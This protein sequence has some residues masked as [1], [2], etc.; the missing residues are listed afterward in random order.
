[1]YPTQS[2]F[3]CLNIQKLILSGSSHS[4]TNKVNRVNSE[5]EQQSYSPTSQSER[6]T[7]EHFTNHRQNRNISGQN[8]SHSHSSNYQPNMY[9]THVLFDMLKDI[10]SRT[11]DVH[12]I[13]QSGKDE[14]HEVTRIPLSI[15]FKQRTY[16]VG[17]KPNHRQDENPSSLE[18]NLNCHRL[19]DDLFITLTRLFVHILLKSR[20]TT[21]HQRSQAIHDKVDIQQMSNLQR[22]FNTKQRTYHSHQSSSKVNRQLH[23]AELQNVMINR[24]AEPNCVLDAIEVI[25]QDNQVTRC[26]SHSSTRAHS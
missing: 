14:E 8:N 21:E 22:L 7:T 12:S 6:H 1:M 24:T 9:V 26:L 10:S 19:I 5:G 25:I 16:K 3:D 15:G 23:L 20:L 18:T 2:L 11:T 17:H 4:L 13:Y